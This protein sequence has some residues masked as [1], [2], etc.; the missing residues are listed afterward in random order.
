MTTCSTSERGSECEGTRQVLKGIGLKERVRKKPSRKFIK[1]PAYGAKSSGAHKHHSHNVHSPKYRPE[2]CPDLCRVFPAKSEI[3]PNDFPQKEN[4]SK[5]LRNRK[6]NQQRA[7]NRRLW[8][9]YKRIYG[10]FGRP[11]KAQQAWR[12]RNRCD[13]HPPVPWRMPFK[14]AF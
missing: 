8:R 1:I 11:A 2:V 5:K 9:Y 14:P 7:C 4:T 6:R 10:K 13:S 12:R 3:P